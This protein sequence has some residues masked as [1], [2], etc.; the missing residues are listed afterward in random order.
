[1]R[2]LVSGVNFLLILLLLI[3]FIVNTGFIIEMKGV[4]SPISYRLIFVDDSGPLGRP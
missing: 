1:M 3:F 4:Y 2:G